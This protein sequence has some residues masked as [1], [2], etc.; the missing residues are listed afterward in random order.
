VTRDFEGPS[1][2]SLGRV[3]HLDTLLDALDAGM[4]DDG[5]VYVEGT[6]FAKDVSA[7]LAALPQAPEHERCGDLQA[8]VWPAPTCFHVPVRSGVL[9]VLRQLA[10][11]WSEPE[12]CDHLVV[13]RG[14]EIL[15]LA[16]DAA[17]GDLLVAR[18][19]S[20]SVV[21]RM[22]TILERD[23]RTRASP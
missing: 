12:I 18:A 21:E 2:L 14:E 6:S 3:R 7:A 9:R 23:R 17:R 5:I 8:T 20:A 10:T 16:H 22:R 4:P 1:V 15:A 13:Y 19:L 11:R